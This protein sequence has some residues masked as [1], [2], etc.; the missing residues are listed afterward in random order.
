[1]LSEF[2][3]RRFHSRFPDLKQVINDQEIDFKIESQVPL[4]YGPNEVYLKSRDNRRTVLTQFS[5]EDHFNYTL[6][7]AY[8]YDYVVEKI[9]K[10]LIVSIIIGIIGSVLIRLFLVD[11]IPYVNIINVAL[12]FSLYCYTINYNIW[13]LGITAYK[14]EV[15]KTPK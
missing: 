12:L 5:V 13:K 4:R 8:N 6:K 15:I 14:I 11:R 9:V 3:K 2:S 7:I 1:M 10:K